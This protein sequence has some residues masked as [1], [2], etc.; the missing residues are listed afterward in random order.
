MVT[1]NTNSTTKA[2]ATAPTVT[3]NPEID[4]AIQDVQ[5]G[6]AAVSGL[7]D[8][9]LAK[10][11]RKRLLKVRGSAAQLMGPLIDLANRMPALAPLDV[12]PQEL[13][14]QLQTYQQLVTLLAIVS[15]GST[16][17]GDTVVQM[18]A[19]LYQAALAIYAIAQQSAAGNAE[20]AYLVGEMKKALSTGPRT[21][22]YIRVPVPKGTKK[23]PGTTS[24][25]TPDP[26]GGSSASSTAA[27]N[28]SGTAP[29]SGSSSTGSGSSSTPSVPVYTPSGVLPPA[30]AGGGGS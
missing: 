8:P 25:A 14:Q 19:S 3:G 2:Q 21:R 24:T 28:G 4:T 15:K 20:V 9:N 1:K 29:V 13:A 26:A 6:L 23:T 5:N 7:M 11:A 12:N 22:T 17:V 10:G 27:S 30:K 18:K 16:D